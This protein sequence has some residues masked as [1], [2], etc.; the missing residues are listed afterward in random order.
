MPEPSLAMNRHHLGAH[1]SSHLWTMFDLPPTLWLL[2]SRCMP[3]SLFWILVRHGCTGLWSHHRV[4]ERSLPRMSSLASCHRCR[5]SLSSTPCTTWLASDSFSMSN[6]TSNFPLRKIA[7]IPPRIPVSPLR[8]KNKNKSKSVAPQPIRMNS[9]NKR[10]RPLAPLRP[11][12]LLLLLHLNRTPLQQHLL[13]KNL[14]W[15]SR[16]VFV[17]CV[18]L[19]MIFVS[20]FWTLR[21]I[22]IV[23]LSLF[24][25]F[26][27]TFPIEQPHS[28]LKTTHFKNYDGNFNALLYVWHIGPS[29]FLVHPKSSMKNWNFDDSTAPSYWTTRLCFESDQ[30]SSFDT[31]TYKHEFLPLSLIPLVLLSPTFPVWDSRSIPR[32]F[33]P[34]TQEVFANNTFIISTYSSSHL[35]GRPI[36]HSLPDWLASFDAPLIWLN[37]L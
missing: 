32:F 13:W 15:N 35:I 19:C 8:N 4:R 7:P 30:S 16:S 37:M 10:N 22:R 2:L 5:H 23:D 24:Y 31:N 17:L 28:I 3:P 9:I 21:C 36:W 34:I 26:V 33:Y 6:T 25:T 20:L 1:L 27:H 14:S 18:F 11:P 29:L 12:R